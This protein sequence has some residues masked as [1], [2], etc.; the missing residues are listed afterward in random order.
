[1]MNRSA[2]VGIK[3]LPPLLK[4]CETVEEFDLW[5]QGYLGYKA[6]HMAVCPNHVSP[7]EAFWSIASDQVE[8]VFIVANR[9]GTKTLGLSALI[10][11]LCLVNPGY[12]VVVMAAALNQAD[13]IIKNIRM[14]FLP[15]LSAFFPRVFTKQATVV[16]AERIVFPT[17]SFVMLRAATLSGA[18]APHPHMVVFDEV[19]CFEDWTIIEEALSMAQDDTTKRYRAHNVFSSSRKFRF[20]IAQKLIEEGPVRGIKVLSWCVFETMERCTEYPEGCEQCKQVVRADGK[21]FWDLCQGKASWSRGY[22]PKEHVIRESLRLSPHTYDAQWL[23]LRPPPVGLVFPDLDLMAVRVDHWHVVPDYAVHIGM[24]F[25][26]QDPTVVLCA[27]QLPDNTIILFKEYVWKQRAL[28]QILPELVQIQRLYQPVSWWCDPSRPDLIAM[29]QEAGLPA[30]AAPRMV[31]A[32]RIDLIRNGLGS[33]PPTIK[34]D[35]TQCPL[36]VNQLQNYHYELDRR[37]GEPTDKLKDGN[38]DSIDALSYLVAGM[39]QG[40]LTA[41]NPY[42]SQP[43]TSSLPLLTFYAGAPTTLS[44]EEALREEIRKRVRPP[45]PLYKILL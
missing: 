9:S 37:T 31:K 35:L 40:T 43:T 36:L 26:F 1:M 4:P 23:G 28:T 16:S 42:A 21:S 2:E 27:Q 5:L 12:E 8:D 7:L 25:G 18:N 15:R 10:T 22:L 30:R 33:Q 19:E 11:Y 20:G 39:A 38:D 24:D 45:T 29:L 17:G 41:A 6:P 13:E 44:I 34:I 32:E 14:K 3:G